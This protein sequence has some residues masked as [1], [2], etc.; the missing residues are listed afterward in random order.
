[1]SCNEVTFPVRKIAAN[2]SSNLGDTSTLAD[3][4]VPAPLIAGR[5]IAGLSFRQKVR[6]AT[7][8][9]QSHA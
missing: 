1:M 7:C 3:S 6:H 2:G 4:S 8:A 5:H 9:D